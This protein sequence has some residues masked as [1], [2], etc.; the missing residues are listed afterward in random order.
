MDI[1]IQKRHGKRLYIV[2]LSRSM[3]TSRHSTSYID[4]KLHGETKIIIKPLFYDSALQYATKHWNHILAIQPYMQNKI[5]KFADPLHMT[6]N[7]R[8]K[9]KLLFNLHMQYD[10]NYDDINSNDISNDHIAKQYEV[11]NSH[12]QIITHSRLINIELSSGAC[13]GT[14]CCHHGILLT[15]ESC[16]MCTG[17]INQ[18]KL[19]PICD[20][21]YDYIKD[22]ETSIRIHSRIGIGQ[23]IVPDRK[24]LQQAKNDSL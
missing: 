11:H 8:T 23:P 22:H 19:S 6:G 10:R 16:P 15:T 4:N 14:I 5:Y 9:A 3:R 12:I 24:L 21:L 18:E 13:V 17:S 20:K 1:R 2:S 7:L